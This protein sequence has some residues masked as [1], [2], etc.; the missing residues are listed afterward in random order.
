[1]ITTRK[2]LAKQEYSA[3]LGKSVVTGTLDEKLDKNLSHETLTKKVFN[4]YMKSRGNR[5][6]FLFMRKIMAA[7]FKNKTLFK[8]T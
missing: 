1:M 8:I 3:L 5:K 2:P 4:T 6:A 7:N